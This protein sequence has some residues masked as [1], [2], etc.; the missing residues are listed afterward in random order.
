MVDCGVNEQGLLYALASTEPEGT[1]QSVSYYP[2]ATTPLPLG[3][4]YTLG[5]RFSVSRAAFG[6]AHPRVLALIE[7]GRLRPELVTTSVVDW[8]DAAD[9]YLQDTIKLVVQRAA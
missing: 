3:R 4:M 6:R 7:S 5:I 1:C 9:A 8:D 2:A